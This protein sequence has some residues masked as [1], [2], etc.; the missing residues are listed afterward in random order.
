M[1]W[2]WTEACTDP[3]RHAHEALV[4]VHG[5]MGRASQWRYQLDGLADDTRV[6]AVDLPAHGQSPGGARVDMPTFTRALH[7]VLSDL[8][9]ERVVLGGHSMGGAV[10]LSYLLDPQYQEEPRP[11]V[12]GLVLVGTGARLRVAPLIVDLT[13]TD[14]PGL[15]DLMKTAVFY[16]KTRR[17]RPE[18]VADV[19]AQIQQVPREVALADWAVCNQFDV[20][21]H[22]AAIVVPALVL[23][24]RRD[25]LT[26]VKYA[27]Y[28]TDHL[29]R[30]RLEVVER[31][32]H[33]VML[34]RPDV[35]NSLVGEFLREVSE[36]GNV[37][38]P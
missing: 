13:R 1:T 10:V 21:D 38:P 34:E 24:G 30:A 17:A 9:V 5:S 36:R 35:V 15:V 33:Y 25:Q 29:P 31:A 18:M 12:S 8:D 4:F 27:Q 2:H 37:N 6:V 11:E 32:G 20:M 16:R 3:S 22:L 19:L 7:E 26:P 23:C 14:F 28:L